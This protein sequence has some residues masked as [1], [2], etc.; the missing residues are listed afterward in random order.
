MIMDTGRGD[1]EQ[2]TPISSLALGHHQPSF[3]YNQN[4]FQSSTPRYPFPASA[5]LSTSSTTDRNKKDLF[6]STSTEMS[7]LS[8][9]IIG[10]S[11]SYSSSLSRSKSNNNPNRRS[12]PSQIGHMFLP[13]PSPLL[14]PMIQRQSLTGLFELD[15]LSLPLA[16]ERGSSAEDE[17]DN[18]INPNVPPDHAHHAATG[19]PSTQVDEQEAANILLALSSPESMAPTPWHSASKGASP[20]SGFSLDVIE[21]QGPVE[22][23][24]G[25]TM[26]MDTDKNMDV[27]D[28]MDVERKEG[29]VH[30]VNLPRTSSVTSSARGGRLA[31]SARDFLNLRDDAFG[32]ALTHVG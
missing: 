2:P 31:K 24:D 14:T 21:E 15:P 17:G 16:L 5:T 6:L 12:S 7:P 23:E 30:P 19:R 28:N 13:E 18:D 26:K 11:S 20:P 29:D 1:S 27:V 3:Q 22:A 4:Q 8:P 9:F 32:F 25:M 10:T